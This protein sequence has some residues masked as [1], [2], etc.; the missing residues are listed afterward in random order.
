MGLQA[1]EAS[2]RPEILNNPWPHRPNVRDEN[3]S[4]KA[5]KQYR[6]GGAETKLTVTDIRH[7]TA[8]ARTPTARDA[9]ECAARTAT[10]KWGLAPNA[11]REIMGISAGPGTVRL[12]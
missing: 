2:N 4:T 10:G 1:E 6:A 11:N 9:P 8:S 5:V 7:N 12:Q 3:N